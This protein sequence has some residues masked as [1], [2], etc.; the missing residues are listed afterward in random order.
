L[1]EGEITEL[2]K[3]IGEYDFDHFSRQNV[4]FHYCQAGYAPDGIKE[5]V[6]WCIRPARSGSFTLTDA[7]TGKTLLEGKLIP[8]GENVWNRRA[9]IADISKL[10]KEGTYKL[11][12]NLGSGYEGKSPPFEIRKNLYAELLEKAARHFFHKRC[13]ITCHTHDA[14]LRST[15]Q[16]DFGKIS[17]HKDVTGGWHDAHDDNK[18]MVYAWHA[19]YALSE[20]QER[21]APEWNSTLD[22]GLPLPL[23][24]AWW[25]IEWFMKMQK[26]DGSFYYAVIDLKPYKKSG[27]WHNMP[28]GLKAPYN[29]L[30]DDDRWLSDTWGTGALDELIGIPGS[31]TPS[32]PEFYHAAVAAAIAK[33]ALACRK[34]DKK[35]SL[36]AL[37]AARA[38][39][40]WVEKR[41]VKPFQYISLQAGLALLKIALY[42]LGLKPCKTQIEKHIRQ[43]L[44]LQQPE[45]HFHTARDLRGLEMHPEEAGDDRVLVDYPFFYL[46]PL[47]E[48]L[49]HFPKG[50]LC[51]KIKR[52]IEKFFALAKRLSALSEFGH[53]PQWT[54]K[55]N[56][57]LILSKAHHGYNPYLL[58]IGA[59]AAMAA[60]VLGDDSLI[61]LAE[62]QLQWVLGANPRAMSFMN[63]VGY[64]RV[65]RNPLFCNRQGRDIKYG[66][67]TG[68][69]GPREGQPPNYPN[70]GLS[71]EGGYDSGA[72]ET[73]INATGWM[74]YLLTQLIEYR[75]S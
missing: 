70:A 46:I 26:G 62:K 15:R 20:L 57:E 23:A 68:I 6:V 63:D 19:V 48:Y 61:A 21:I 28:W 56:P 9:F 75:R 22:E 29:D 12:A 53:L 11:T 71:E 72:E 31:L 38:A 7:K 44:A 55:D 39:M 47:F 69:Y 10:K 5:I 49:R 13:G 25:E 8:R 43:I 51:S 2:Q 3:L 32:T 73:W 16:K 74:V 66:V 52:A 40:R 67:T 45:G 33:F 18:W 50:P 30:V 65:N 41:K 59:L 14:Y 54:A 24:E 1:A 34:C 42:R 17:G 36:T 27:K 64:R 60:K 35:K 37:R 58:S 4:T